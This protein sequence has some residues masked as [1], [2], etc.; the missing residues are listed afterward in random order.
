MLIHCYAVIHPK[1]VDQLSFMWWDFFL[2]FGDTGMNKADKL[3]SSSQGTYV[4]LGPTL[5]AKII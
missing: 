2:A 4:P 1:T 3:L 5:N